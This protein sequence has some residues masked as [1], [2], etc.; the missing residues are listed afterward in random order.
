MRENMNQ[1]YAI[2]LAGGQGSRFWPLSRILEPKQF[3]SLHNDK[4]LFEE[5]LSRIKPLIPRKNI[6][7]CTS[8]LY[9]H[10]ICEFIKPFDIPQDNLIFEPEGKNTA[11]SI[12]LATFLISLRNPK[13]LISV[14]PCDHLISNKSLFKYLLNLA[15]GFCHDHLIILGIPPTRPAIGY[16]YIKAI[17]QKPAKTNSPMYKV[18][19]FC[20]KPDLKTA[21]QFLK[22]K[23][24]FWNSG[25]FVGSARKFSEAFRLCLPHLYRQITQ[26]DKSSDIHRVWHA[27][28]P[29]SFDYG[30]LE[31]TKDLLMLKAS[32]LGWSD[33]GSWQ[34]WDELI[35]KDENGN[36]LMTDVIN[37][38]SRNVSILGN[39]R[40]VAAI[41]L[42]DLIVVDTPDALLITK[43]DRSEE[44]KKVVDI[45]KKKKR[46]EHYIHRTVKRPWGS[47]TV[48]DNGMGF[49]IKLV[50]VN[51]KKS[52]SL[53][54]HKK[55]SEH[56]VV[57]EGTAK[58][59]KGRKSYFVHSNESTFIPL[60]CVHRLMNPG[61]SILRVVEV[62]SG[63]YLE[64]DDIIRLKDD[65]GRE[66]HKE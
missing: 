33:L 29:I 53:Q 38:G 47:Y 12:A 26:I 43:K 51:P 56:W 16:G 23:I 13:A 41:G 28:K 19:R 9:R 3:L 39:K 62:Q 42:E 15:F 44:V 25:I 40:I 34:A 7:I 32:N 35:K 2:L 65:F 1:R 30:V 57:V 61:D 46:P 17:Q 63:D 10:Q 66:F 24:Y 45:L 50:E 31:K 60:S 22:Q 54:M 37:L 64:E 21:Q 6:F 59:W 52:L 27:I 55:R 49:K 11:P 36:V 18:L 4:S 5:T 58:V 8:E 20:E 48:L 14:F